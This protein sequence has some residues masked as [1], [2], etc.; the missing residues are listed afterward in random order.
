MHF[1]GPS[2]FVNKV[3]FGI[4]SFIESVVESVP[5]GYYI[6]TNRL[7]PE[8]EQGL[9]QKTDLRS[10]DRIFNNQLISIMSE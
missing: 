2:Q 9:K 3:V 6:S 4:F 1:E 10:K 5:L 8:G 7:N